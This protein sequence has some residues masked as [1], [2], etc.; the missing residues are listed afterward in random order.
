MSFPSELELSNQKEKP[1]LF[2]KLEIIQFVLPNTKIKLSLQ[3]S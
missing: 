2:T 1:E 3:K